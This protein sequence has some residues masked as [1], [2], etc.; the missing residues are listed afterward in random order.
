MSLKYEPV[1]EPLHM[2]VTT[3][4]IVQRSGLRVQGSGFLSTGVPPT[5][6]AFLQVCHM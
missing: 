4:F 6:A 3:W 5:A 2:S 1:S